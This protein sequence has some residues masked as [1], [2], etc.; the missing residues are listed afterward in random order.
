MGRKN[1]GKF[2]RGENKGK[3]KR[4]KMKGKT[5]ESFTEEVHTAFQGKTC[6]DFLVVY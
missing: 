2:Q 3:D 6:N 5:L 4:H 1:H